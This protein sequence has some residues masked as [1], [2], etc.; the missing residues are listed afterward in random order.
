MVSVG[1][2]VSIWR[3]DRATALFYAGLVGGALLTGWLGRINV[4]GSLNV[5]M[6]IYAAVAITTSLGL[7]AAS[8]VTFNGELLLQRA[9]RIAVHIVAL[10]QLA[11]LFYDPRIVVPSRE[12][13]LFSNQILSGLRSIDGPILIMDDRFF[14]QSLDKSSAGLDYSLTDLLQ[15][16]N[17]PVTIK[18]KD[19]I[20]EALRARKFAGVV[21]PAAFITENLELDRPVRIQPDIPNHRRT[22]FTPKLQSYYAVGNSQDPEK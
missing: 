17:S 21:D 11:V 2:I 9:W 1:W 19:S 3:S 18:L 7:Q 5:L 14:A 6:P 12:D 15:H 20:V 8:R 22:R 10:V 13:K 4:A 16:K